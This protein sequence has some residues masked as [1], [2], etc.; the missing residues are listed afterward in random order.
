M[1]PTVLVSTTK[2][3]L[4]EQG[5]GVTVDQP[6]NPLQPF[7]TIWPAQ[8]LWLFLAMSLA[9][10]VTATTSAMRLLMSISANSVNQ[11]WLGFAS[12]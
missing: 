12:G 9:S 3:L 1:D 8:P 10:I 2:N 11:M 4:V 7:L 5:V 6:E